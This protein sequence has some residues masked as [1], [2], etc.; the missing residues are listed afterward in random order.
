MEKARKNE[1]SRGCRNGS[2][3]LRSYSF[4]QHPMF[5]KYVFSNYLL[6]VYYGGYFAA[7]TY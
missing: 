1:G 7:S 2:A 5:S 6:I 4:L 3:Y